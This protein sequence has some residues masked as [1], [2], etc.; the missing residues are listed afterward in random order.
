MIRFKQLFYERKSDERFIK[1][2][3]QLYLSILRS[4]KNTDGDDITFI[5]KSKKNKSVGIRIDVSEINPKYDFTIDIVTDSDKVAVA[6]YDYG[7]KNIVVN[8]RTISKNKE[9]LQ[10][11]DEDE[12]YNYFIKNLPYF[13]PRT[14]VIH[15]IIHYFDDKYNYSF[16]NDISLKDIGSGSEYFNS[17]KEINAYL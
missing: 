7:D 11:Q 17:F 2:A 9:W 15:E 12:F 13:L 5:I 4:I 6:Y 8:T 10:I 3:N 14:E 1:M 16:D